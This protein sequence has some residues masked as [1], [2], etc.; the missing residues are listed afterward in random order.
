MKLCY[1]WE[2][3]KKNEGY[4]LVWGIVESVSFGVGSWNWHFNYSYFVKMK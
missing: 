2:V 1:Y 4:I 3:W